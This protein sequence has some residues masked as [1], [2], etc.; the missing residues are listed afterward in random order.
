MWERYKMKTWEWIA[1]ILIMLIIAVV[2]L[3]LV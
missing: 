2:I 3:S 1:G